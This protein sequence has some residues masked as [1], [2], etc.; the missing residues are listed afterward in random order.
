MKVN[1]WK[2]GGGGTNKNEVDSFK[3][4]GRREK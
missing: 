4:G 2:E 3:E 1:L